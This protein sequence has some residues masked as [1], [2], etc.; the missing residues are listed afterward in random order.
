MLATM[1]RLLI[2]WLLNALALVITAYVVPDFEVD[3]FGP[4]V[5]GALVVGLLNVTLGWLLSIFTFPLVW[6]LPR[7]MM[8]LIDA[9]VLYVAAKLVPGFRIKSFLAAFI[10]AIVLVLIHIVFS[11][12]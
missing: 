3:G 10:G 5:I 11:Y 12:A 6:L 2:E 4:A 1:I 8:V 7:L 9:V